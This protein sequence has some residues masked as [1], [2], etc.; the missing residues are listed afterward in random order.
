MQSLSIRARLIFA[1]LLSIVLLVLLAGLGIY[2]QQ[3]A[4]A[5]F[6]AARDHAVKPLL[7]IS[8]IDAGL[9]EIRFRMAGVA[10]DTVSTLGSR[11]QLKETREQLPVLWRDFVAG[12][13]GR[14]AEETRAVE[15]IGKEIENLPAIFDA[16]DAA[17]A[18][19]DRAAVLAVL[20]DKW[21]RVHKNIIRPLGELLPVLVASMNATFA[22]SEQEGRRLSMIAVG[23]NVAGIVILALVLLQ[24]IPSLT[25]GIADI[26]AVLARMAEGELNVVPDT[27]RG[28]ELGDMA[29]SL[30]ATLK[31]LREIISG[32]QG[33]AATLTSAAERLQSELVNV[34]ERGRA[35]GEFM[36]RAA[37]G[38]DQTTLSAKDVAASSNQVA[39][40]SAESRTVAASGNARMEKSIAAIR[41]VESTVDQSAT[42][43]ADLSSET[44]RIQAITQVIREIADQ[45]NLLA[46]N[47]A[48]EA[49]RAG[50]QGR[51]FAV[52]ADE[53]RKL[54]ERTSS[55]TSDIANTV[56]AIR[57]KAVTAVQAMHNVHDEVVESVRFSD[58]TRETL[59]AIVASAERVSE[60]AR[61][62]AAATQ[63]QLAASERTVGEMAQVSAMSNDNSAAIK[64]V[65]DVTSEV[66]QLA[67][68]MQALIG[69]FRV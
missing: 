66:D 10:L 25:R 30:E 53:V 31:S 22:S 16:L 5:A 61:G 32:V 29:R 63:S 46:L 35:R 52:V 6:G 40:A 42:V 57:G 11:Q 20:N 3:R 15:A 44:E 65:G 51:G 55:S 7:A 67:H 50:E 17:Y 56:E 26:R 54:A 4:S 58:E 60:L 36:A 27:R 19:E 18:T 8:E 12:H 48:I 38:I 43:M 64:R 23:A 47:A 69:R 2:G 62:I 37:E 68:Q 14:T 49:A 9:K 1:G 13:R 34:T 41:R 28:D 39:E 33:S 45:T 21:P 24:V 59:G